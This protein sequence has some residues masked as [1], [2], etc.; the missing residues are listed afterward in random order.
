MLISEENPDKLIAQGKS[1]AAA[2]ATDPA[3][4]AREIE[5]TM[6]GAAPETCLQAFLMHPFVPIAVRLTTLS[7]EG[8]TPDEIAG[9]LSEIEKHVPTE[10]APCG[11]VNDLRRC[12]VVPDDWDALH[13]EGYNAIPANNLVHGYVLTLGAMRNAPVR[14]ALSLQIMLAEHLEGFFGT[15]PSIYH[16]VIAPMFRAYWKDAIDQSLVLFNKSETYTRRQLQL[17]DGSPHGTRRL[18]AAMVFCLG[19]GVTP[20]TAAWLNA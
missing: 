19:V 15:A 14:A 16:Y 10:K 20:E 17:A 11:F 12:L 3:A 5:A 8:A 9:Y 6:A 1:L 4:K 7:I 2:G 13:Q 18:L